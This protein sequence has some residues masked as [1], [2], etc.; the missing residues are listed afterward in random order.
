MFFAVATLNIFYWISVQC[1]GTRGSLPEGHP[2]HQRHI[3]RVAGGG[4]AAVPFQFL[5]LDGRKMPVLRVRS[6]RLTFNYLCKWFEMSLQPLKISG[7]FQR[8]GMGVRPTWSLVNLKSRLWHSALMTLRTSLGLRGSKWRVGHNLEQRQEARLEIYTQDETTR[9]QYFCDAGRFVFVSGNDSHRNRC[10]S[11]PSLR[12]GLHVHGH[13]HSD[14]DGQRVDQPL[15]VSFCLLGKSWNIQLE[16]K[17][18]K[19][20]EARPWRCCEIKRGYLYLIDGV[21]DDDYV[22]L[23]PRRQAFQ[24]AR[25]LLQDLAGLHGQAGNG[26]E[27]LQ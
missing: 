11:P 5:L 13:H 6:A 3:Q 7:G 10:A 14:V 18:R 22:P 12:A 15:H 20:E 9:K 26:P 27:V 19:Y 21:D 24:P 8:R 23:V 25:K 17:K 16:K 4:G 2:G 1:E